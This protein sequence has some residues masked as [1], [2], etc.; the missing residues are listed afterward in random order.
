MRKTI[1]AMLSLAAVLCVSCE[2]ETSGNGSLDG[3]WQL[4]QV[5]TIGGSSADMRAKGVFWAVQTDLLEA[6]SASA[7]VFFRF[8]YTGDSLFLSDPYMNNRDSSD[9]KV[10]DASQLT[11]LGIN[12]LDER[13]RV[14]TL[15]G[16]TMVL[17]SDVLLLSFRKY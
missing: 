1:I 11:S 10:T 9:I 7:D 16:G 6:R 5:D 3:F 17:R 4:S 14:V 8:S 13:F 2:I 12:S 15:D